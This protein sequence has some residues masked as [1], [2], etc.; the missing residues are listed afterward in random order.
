MPRT[1][2]D[3]LQ[4]A[5]RALARNPGASLAEIAVS[6]NVSRSTLYRAYPSREALV[7]ALA[8][9]MI[10][11]LRGAMDEAELESSPPEK[12]LSGLVE[13]MLDVGD[14]L[15]LTNLLPELLTDE[16]YLSQGA[17]L[18][19]RL[20]GF[21]ERARDEGAVRLDQPSRWHGYAL[22]ALVSA[23]ADGVRHGTLAPLDAFHLVH[24]TLLNGI[25]K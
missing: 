13:R 2:G 22:G 10:D 3:L 18:D 25:G 4:L 14:L 6:A 15:S 17:E 23:A 9:R 7:R 20:R 8:R 21:F 16:D 5:G 19:E 1:Q 24:S 12:A 11:D